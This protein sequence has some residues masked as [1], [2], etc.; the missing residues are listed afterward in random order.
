VCIQP[1]LSCSI[2]KIDD[3]FCS[4]GGKILF[5]IFMGILLGIQPIVILRNSGN[6]MYTCTLTCTVQLYC[7]LVLYTCTVQLY[8]TLVLYT[9]TVHLYCRLVMY[10]C[11]VHLCC[12]LLLYTC[13][14]HLYCTIVLYTCIVHLCC[15]LVLYT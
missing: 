3:G 13:T 1:N 4:A 8:C 15:T 11:T 2:N 10:T 5:K 7:R 14:V 12:T 6:N 9:C